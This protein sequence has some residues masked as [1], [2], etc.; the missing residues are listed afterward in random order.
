M[1]R[2]ALSRNR[3]IVNTQ[4]IE[5][6]RGDLS[7]LNDLKIPE[8]TKTNY[9]KELSVPSVPS[10]Q[11]HQTVQSYQKELSQKIEN[12]KAFIVSN[13]TNDS[14]VTI[15][16]PKHY[17]GEVLK[18]EGITIQVSTSANNKSEI[19]FQLSQTGEQMVGYQSRDENNNIR[20][21]GIGKFKV[22]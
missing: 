13:I 5:N 11:N 15:S 2:Q 21:L 14:E 6:S 19:N 7:S 3:E 22:T 8:V 4:N 10:I 1:S 16:I 9:Q 18:G 20:F 12:I 17:S